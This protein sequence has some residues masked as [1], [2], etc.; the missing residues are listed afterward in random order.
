MLPQKRRVLIVL[1]IAEHLAADHVVPIQQAVGVRE[2]RGAAAVQK[3]GARQREFPVHVSV[4]IRQVVPPLYHGVV[5]AGIVQR[6]PRAHIRVDRPQLREGRTVQRRLQF[7]QRGAH[8]LRRRVHLLVVPQGVPRVHRQQHQQHRHHR[9]GQIVKKL[10]HLVRQRPHLPHSP[11][12]RS[13][14]MTFPATFFS[15]T[16]PKCRLSS[17]C[18]R[19]SFSRNRQPSGTV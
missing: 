6:H 4:H 5:H 16:P 15:G 10:Q 11:R 9:A 19:Q 12:R 3:N 7:Q 13:S 1:Q 18:V 2:I 8:L 17:P 14:V